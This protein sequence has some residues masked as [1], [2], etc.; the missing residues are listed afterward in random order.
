M[1]LVQS[2]KPALRLYSSDAVAP[3]TGRVSQDVRLMRISGG[4]WRV[5]ECLDLPY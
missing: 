4:Y 3:E 2:E 5:P 1:H